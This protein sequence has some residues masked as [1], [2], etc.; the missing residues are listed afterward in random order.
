MSARCYYIVLLMLWG[1]QA[2]AQRVEGLTC[3]RRSSPE[4]ID[5]QHPRLSWRIVGEGKDLRQTAYQVI[6]ASTAEK[7]A[8]DEGAHKEPVP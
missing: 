2:M 6:V 7:L 1:M 3:E 4:G 5:V 8:A